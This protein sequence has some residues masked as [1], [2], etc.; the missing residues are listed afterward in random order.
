MKAMKS[1]VAMV[2]GLGLG[3]MVLAGMR[4]AWAQGGSGHGPGGPPPEA[5]TACEGK[6]EGDQCSFERRDGS[7]VEGVCKKDRRD[8]DKLVCAPNGPPPGGENGP[9]AGPGGPP[10]EAFT[11]CAGKAEGDQCSFE[12]R[13]GGTVDGVC[14]KDRKDTDKLVCAP[15]GPPPGGENGP[16]AGP[17][18]Q[19]GPPP[20][21]FA[22]CEG[23]AE[24]D[25]CSFTRRDGSTV[26]GACRKDR[27]DQSK[28]VCA[29]NNPP[30]GGGP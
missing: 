30:P 1:A 13:D 21:A 29:P 7:T 19:G 27:P 18:G 8:A 17:G 5:F 24:G 12:R 4:V 3:V 23:K 15:N 16:G 20:E 11:A 14:R 6:A 9:G 26:D 22:A 10:P 2:L 25:Q 28:L